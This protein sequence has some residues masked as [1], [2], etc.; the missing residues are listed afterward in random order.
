V[1]IAGLMDLVPFQLIAANTREVCRQAVI[2][3]PLSLTCLE[4]AFAAAG[5]LKVNT[6]LIVD[7]N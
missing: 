7:E 4:K 3:I 1:E 5:V 2:Q 6:C